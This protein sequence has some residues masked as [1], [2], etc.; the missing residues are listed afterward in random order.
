MSAPAP[1]SIC[2]LE[3][4]AENRSR[5][6]I[7]MLLFAFAVVPSVVL[8]VQFA[9]ALVL[10]L[11]R[12]VVEL[13]RSVERWVGVLA[14]LIAYPLVQ[15]LICA[16]P[17]G[18]VLRLAGARPAGPIENEYS[19]TV[20]DIAQRAGVPQPAAYVIERAAPNLFSTG[21]DPAHSSIVATTGLLD[22][23]TPA[24]REA[25]L[26]HE[27]SHIA[28]LDTRVS[29]LSAA[30]IAV[31]RLPW[32]MFLGLRPWLHSR[33]KKQGEYTPFYS[34]TLGYLQWI[35]IAVTLL[36]W[37]L[38]LWSLVYWFSDYRVP[39]IAILA[40]S[41]LA[42]AAAS[43][44]ETLM[45]LML[46]P[47][48]VLLI[49]PLLAPLLRYATPF[50]RESLADADAA[51]LTGTPDGILGALLKLKGSRSQ[52]LG[53]P[54]AIGHLCIVDPAAHALGVASATHPQIDRRIALLG[55][56]GS[57]ISGQT[58]KTLEEIGAGHTGRDLHAPSSANQL[59]SKRVD[60]SVGTQYCLQAPASLFEAPD[61][62]SY[63]ALKLPA[64][65]EVVVFEKS[66]R[67]F[68]AVAKSGMFGF[69][70]I[71]TPMQRLDGRSR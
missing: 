51:S 70:S 21:L 26:A 64:G 59:L 68:Q 43:A 22:L 57:G 56:A 39:L 17:K 24:E 46:I 23:L 12:V 62:K 6:R 52:Q 28:N 34:V 8:F 45:W 1:K 25:V 65:A 27:I 61:P 30:M 14:I 4:T 19:R 11:G 5:S 15:Y 48:W 71:D 9:V 35:W 10:A 58:A 53:V 50:T 63:V 3:R 16:R 44:G 67:F 42:R 13:P 41:W 49:A 18:L 20:A 29:T 32:D 33:A 54:R 69:L 66:G 60:S 47:M 37:T 40:P 38:P 36:T 7:L 55:G 31:L 2:D